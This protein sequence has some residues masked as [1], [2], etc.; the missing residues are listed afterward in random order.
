MPPSHDPRDP[1]AP[2]SCRGGAG[3]GAGGAGRGGPGLHF[4]LATMWWPCCYTRTFSPPRTNTVPSTYG[5]ILRGPSNGVYSPALSPRGHR[6]RAASATLQQNRTG[7]RTLHRRK[8]DLFSRSQSKPLGRAQIICK[9]KWRWA[10][11]ENLGNKIRGKM[12][13]MFKIIKTT[14]SGLLHVVPN[15][16]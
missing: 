12:P 3:L 16:A 6:L 14:H 8:I 11:C 7:R 5:A 13:F 1:R 4:L 9:S 2:R 15:E 10:T